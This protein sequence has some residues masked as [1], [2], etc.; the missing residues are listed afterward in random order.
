MYSLG[1]LI[2]ELETARPGED[3][4]MFLRYQMVH[5][6]VDLA[7]SQFRWAVRQNWPL[8]WRIPTRFAFADRMNRA[9]VAGDRAKWGLITLDSLNTEEI[10][11]SGAP[12]Q[13]PAMLA[14]KNLGAER[15]EPPRTNEPDVKAKQQ[16]EE[17]RHR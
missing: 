14:H 8:I 5:Q 10:A 3:S 11:K 9:L 1:L 17:N 12:R 16:C 15:S 4:C 13:T 6:Q 2:A 7:R